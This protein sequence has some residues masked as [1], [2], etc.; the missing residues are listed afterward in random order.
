MQSTTLLI[1]SSC[2]LLLTITMSDEE[3]DDTNAMQQMMGF[4]SFGTSQRPKKEP[5]GP[6][7]GEFSASG[8]NSA[9]LAKRAKTSNI[10]SKIQPLSSS[11]TKF[12]PASLPP[13]PKSVAPI[14]TSSTQSYITAT[15]QQP[16]PGA[17]LAVPSTQVPS[18]GPPSGRSLPSSG[19]QDTPYAPSPGTTV[20]FQ[21]LQEARFTRPPDP[22]AYTNPSSGISFTRQE[23][24]ELRNGKRNEKGDVVFFQPSFVDPD[25]WAG[26][27]KKAAGRAGF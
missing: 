5:Q 19:L 16:L 2:Q 17:S 24:N 8:A 10:T 7:N 6:T 3:G 27:K 9:P 21:S 25:P 14:G 13:P 4:S 18:N 12:W 11:P 26:L 23:L 20:P 1:P 22:P 15:E